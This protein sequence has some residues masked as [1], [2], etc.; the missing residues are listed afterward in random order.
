MG[1]LKFPWLNLFTKKYIKRPGP[2]ASPAVARRRHR[3][4]LRH[5]KI[6]HVIPP[7]PSPVPGI[8]YISNYSFAF[9]ICNCKLLFAIPHQWWKL[10]PIKIML[11]EPRVT[12]PNL[13]NLEPNYMV[14]SFH[15]SYNKL[16]KTYKLLSSTVLVSLF[17]MKNKIWWNL[18]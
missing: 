16:Y 6:T 14:N 7:S 1:L 17:H 4:H 11:I 10:N 9:I 5:G 8:P 12:T 13:I 3:H 2:V 18:G 15:I